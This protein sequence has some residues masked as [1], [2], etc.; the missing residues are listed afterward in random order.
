MP[1]IGP[2]DATLAALDT[3]DVT[4]AQLWRYAPGEIDRGRP[5]PGTWS[6]TELARPYVVL[7]AKPTDRTR[8]PTGGR[9]S[10]AI[11]LICATR[12]HVAGELALGKPDRLLY[13]G[14]WWAAVDCRD[15]L[16]QSNYFAATFEQTDEPAGQP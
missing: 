3:S 8:R 13:Q 12:V 9:R 4:P 14:V 1:Q 7:P 11:G 15:W 2:F 5:L 16:D 10:A 6:Q